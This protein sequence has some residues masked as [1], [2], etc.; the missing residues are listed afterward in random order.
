MP[1]RYAIAKSTAIALFLAS[2][3]LLAQATPDPNVTPPPQ[4]TPYTLHV[5]ANLT[6]VPT[7]VINPDGKPIQPLT[8]DKFAI[9]LD[10]GP[11]FHPTQLRIEGDDAISLAIVIDDSGTQ[12]HFISDIAES[13]ARLAPK[14]LH[15]KDHVSIYAVDCNI[16]QSVNDVPATSEA[17]RS[18]VTTVLNQPHLHGEKHKP[19]CGNSL[20]LWDAVGIATQKLG[21]VPSRRAVL[22]VSLGHEK[23]SV[24]T[25]DQIVHIAQAEA[26]AIFPLRDIAE[27][28]YQRHFE[29]QTVS[30]LTGATT[31]AIAPTV[32]APDPLSSL[33]Q[34]T[35]G[36]AFDIQHSQ[37]DDMLHRFIGMLRSRYIVE[38]PRPDNML[39]GS[40]M[41]AISIPSHWT[42]LIRNTGTSIPLP[43][44]SVLNDP[45][46]VP[47]AP[48]PATFGNKPPKKQ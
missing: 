36:V 47:S 40:H 15:P 7:L 32:T 4:L 9:S 10:G 5:Y 31:K 3:L 12:L 42:Y 39:E 17:I 34:L 22:L 19:S 30:G 13:L 20:H 18:G 37:M 38:F 45:N 28:S 24:A 29:S 23:G 1:T 35:G 16:V 26:A 8:S 46:T 33:A 14:D 6:Q 43:D 25:F 44:P 21:N 2:P 41:I 27:F 11:A 48:S